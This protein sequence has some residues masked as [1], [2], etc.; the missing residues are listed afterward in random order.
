MPPINQKARLT[1]AAADMYLVTSG[2]ALAIGIL[3]WDQYL[4]RLRFTRKNAE[5][6][7]LQ[8]NAAD[9]L[10]VSENSD[11]EE[12]WPLGQPEQSGFETDP[13]D[14]QVS[15]DADTGL[16]HFCAAGRTGLSHWF[17]HQGDPDF[18]PSIPHGHRVSGKR[19][20]LDAY[21]GWIYRED[22]QAGRE[23]RWKIIAL[24]NDEKF[25]AFASTAIAYYLAAFPGY[26]WRVPNPMRLP[27]LR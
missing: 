13:S 22:Q 3:S 4:L 9:H 25:R 27:R 23:P 8:A 12:E 10:L 5:P 14:S 20:K 1:A 15:E 26:Q 17:F 2:F 16:L 7:S 6:T 24:W 19:K 11:N 18:F 21:R